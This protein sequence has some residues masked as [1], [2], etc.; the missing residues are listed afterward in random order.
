MSALAALYLA[1]FH[2]CI[3]Y[4]VLPTA[5]K[6]I[7]LVSLVSLYLYQH[8]T[9]CVQVQTEL[10]SEVFAMHLSAVHAQAQCIL[11]Q[12]NNL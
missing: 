12:R 2:C 11:L 3:R 4:W 9:T 7:Q 5:H 1:M 6:C 8:S 10:S